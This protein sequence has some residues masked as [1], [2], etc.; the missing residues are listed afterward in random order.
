[1]VFYIDVSNDQIS[2]LIES[3]ALKIKVLGSLYR[4]VRHL[5]SSLGV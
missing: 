3:T 5:V 1:M 2:M 4:K